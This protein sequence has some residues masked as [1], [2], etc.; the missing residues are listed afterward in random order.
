LFNEKI[1]GRKDECALD[2]RV[3]EILE[4]YNR[5]VEYSFSLRDIKVH[6]VSEYMYIYICIVSNQNSF[7][8]NFQMSHLH[9][10]IITQ[11]NSST[12]HNE[13][14]T[15]DDNFSIDMNN[16]IDQNIALNQSECNNNILDGKKNFRQKKLY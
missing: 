3:L 1:F 12:I 9:N 2:Y 13:C 6:I 14:Q 16:D 7:L 4:S 5:N 10:T 8:A 15:G 11:L